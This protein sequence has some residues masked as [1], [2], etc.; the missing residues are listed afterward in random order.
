A[1]TFIESTATIAVAAFR[2]RSS[3]ITAPL[4]ARRAGNL[5][6]NGRVRTPLRKRSV[7]GRLRPNINK[8]ANHIALL[9]RRS[10]MRAICHRCATF[11][12][13]RSAVE[14]MAIELGPLF[15]RA[16]RLVASESAC[17]GEAGVGIEPA[18]TAL[19]AAA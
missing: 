1:S 3:G 13:R 4:K 7:V 18:S 2:V 15:S 14:P 17:H 12:I 6:R 9:I 19:Q 10:C 16:Y 8:S 11:T 5:A